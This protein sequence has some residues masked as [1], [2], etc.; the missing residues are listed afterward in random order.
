MHVIV[1]ANFDVHGDMYIYV[2]TLCTC[3]YVVVQVKQMGY[4]DSRIKLVNEMLNGIKVE[5]N[6][7][8][9]PANQYFVHCII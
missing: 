4:K 6:K 8:V 5:H 3:M 1:H 2:C 7:D 9:Y